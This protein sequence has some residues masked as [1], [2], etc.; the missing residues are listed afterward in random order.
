MNQELPL[1][2]ARYQVER[3]LGSGGLGAVY[4]CLDPMLQRKVAVK[5]LVA[6]GAEA[7][8]R[9][10][11]EARAA[12]RLSHPNVAGLHDMGR[13]DDG[14]IFVVQELVRGL[15]LGQ[16]IAAHPQ[17]LA[18]PVATGLLAQVALAL[19]YAHGHGIVHRD[20]KPGNVMVLATGTAKL[21]DFG[22]ARLVHEVSETTS[23]GTVVGTPQYMAPEQIRGEVPTAS[24]DI[25]AFGALAYELLCGHKPHGAGQFTSLLKQVLLDAPAPLDELAPGVPPPLVA[26]VMRCLAKQAADR[27]A[28][29]EDVAAQLQAMPLRWDDAV[30]PRAPVVPRV[31]ASTTTLSADTLSRA[32]PASPPLTPTALPPARGGDLCGQTVGRFVLHERVSR[33]KSGDLYKAWDPVRG[34]L[35]GVKIVHANDADAR[36]RLLRGG[37]IWIA[38]SHPHIVRVFEVHPDYHGM[39]GVIVTELVDGINLDAL[40][41][42]RHL[43]LAQAVWI[44]MQVCDGLA[45]I[46]ARHVVHREVKPR[47]ILV[48]GPELHVTLLDSGIARHENPEVDA[49]TKTGV[50]VG[51]LAY[52]APEMATGQADQRSDVYAAAAVL[53][54]LVTRSKLPFPLPGDWRPSAGS[55]ADMPARLASAIERGLR[56][57]PGQRFASIVELHDQLRPLAGERRSL[58]NTLAVVALHG[59]R[60]QAAWQ[61]AFSEVA[62][63]HG[64]SAHVDR[65]N[66]GYFSV[67]RFLMP[68]ARLAKVRWFRETYQ[69]EFREAAAVHERPS[70]VAHSFGTYVLGN[71]LLRYPYLCFDKVLLCGSILPRSFP[72]ERLIERGQVQA[73]RN[74]YGRHD[75]WTRAVGWFV[76]AT[77]PSGLS[78]F[79]AEHTRLE[80]ERFE[81]EHSEYFER[82]HMENRWL[83]FLT[84]EIEQRPMREQQVDPPALEIRPWGLYGLY[85]LLSVLLLVLAYTLPGR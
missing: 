62:A 42:Q 71:A 1:Q 28:T 37:R 79:T 45:V 75:V 65:W 29:M 84:A 66:F 15:E 25:Y 83:P 60:T 43:S 13:T 4:E 16:L 22:I 10:L 46:H 23:P 47:N 67:F 35:V 41:A 64:V 44:V 52:A 11:T 68:W 81:F 54:E 9:F 24:V 61:R 63:R 30:L 5:L 18:P 50:F 57:D 69:Q 34:A 56:S 77:G 27:P 85:L 82:G 80:Q 32:W 49:F 19:A 70:I 51:D 53:Y 26:L 73:V 59:I 38:L 33:G 17:G 74:E 8:Q 20:V 14:H 12:A 7:E 40:V 55:V 58:Q 48:S 76:P 36:E 72:W 78:G 31:A 2:I 3:K 39:P 21:L 6:H